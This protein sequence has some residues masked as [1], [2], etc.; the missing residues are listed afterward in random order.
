VADEKTLSPKQA[1]V[2]E[3]IERTIAEAGRPPTYRDIARE[4]GYSAV[5]TVQDHVAALIRKGFLTRGGGLARGIRPSHQCEAMSVPIL[6]MVPAGRPIEAIEERQGSLAVSAASLPKRS[7]HA[8][9]ALRV[10]GESMIEAGI[11]HGDYVIVR[12]QSEARNG[13]IVVA[14]IEGEATVKYFEKKGSHVRLLPANPKFEPIDVPAES[15]N[16]IQGK[17][18]GVQRYYG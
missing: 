2:L 8:V 3:V 13:E 15:A 5:G 9:Y 7:M 10:S 1:K 12:Q 4:L 11:M 18:I 16:F 6:G 17:V 14:M